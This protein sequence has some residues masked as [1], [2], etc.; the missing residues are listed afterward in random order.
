MIVV[1]IAIKRNGK[2][3]III[4]KKAFQNAGAPSLGSFFCFGGSWYGIFA[5]R[6]GAE[7]EQREERSS[8]G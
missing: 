7:E 1:I 6:K 8:P 5:G 3:I 4:I 2:I